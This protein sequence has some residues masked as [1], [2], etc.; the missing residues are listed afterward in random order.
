MSH[1]GYIKK[2]KHKKT[3]VY[4]IYEPNQLPLQIKYDF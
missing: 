4:D 1:R 2:Q 3:L